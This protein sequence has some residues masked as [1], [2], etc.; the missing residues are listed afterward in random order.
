VPAAADEP[1]RGRIAGIPSYLPQENLA[2]GLAAVE[3]S[4]MRQTQPH[5]DLEAS[6]IGNYPAQLKIVVANHGWPDR[7][8][9][10]TRPNYTVEDSIN[11]RSSGLWSR[12]T[13][14]IKPECINVIQPIYQ[15]F[16]VNNGKDM[17]SG[18]NKDDIVT[19]MKEALWARSQT[20][21]G[22][23]K[24]DEAGEEADEGEEGTPPE[25]GD[26]PMPAWYN[27]GAFFLTWLEMGPLSDNH[28]AAVFQ[29]EGGQK[30]PTGDGRE[31]QRAA[32]SVE[33]PGS[34]SGVEKK[35]SYAEIMS[36]EAD[37]E[38]WKT[39]QADRAQTIEEKKL[40]I[41]LEDDPD[42]KKTLKEELKVWLK[43]NPR[44]KFGSKPP[45]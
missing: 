3:A 20:P 32:D 26:K 2:I 44:P 39:Q 19:F 13:Q 21:K 35:G 11:V 23:P 25:E 17:P 29:M 42:A 45:L 14:V 37:I 38:L 24:V 8:G 16:H 41:E 40:A 7:A 43:E 5:A 15:K 4:E 12:W 33:G 9:P 22:T 34:S 27:G 30:A 18:T 10:R 6:T 36:K 31:A 28:R 1:K